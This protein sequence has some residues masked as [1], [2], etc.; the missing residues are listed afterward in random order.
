VDLDGCADDQPTQLIGFLEKEMHVACFTKA[1]KQT[2]NFV[3][4]PKETVRL[5]LCSRGA[6]VFGRSNLRTD[7]RV[8]IR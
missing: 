1:N 6:P 7:K 5:K 2:K 4:H 8:R 3:L